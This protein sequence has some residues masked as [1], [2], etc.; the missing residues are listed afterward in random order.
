M[1]STNSKIRQTLALPKNISKAINRDEIKGCVK[2]AVL[3]AYL[4]PFMV[5]L[6]RQGSQE[7]CRQ[8]TLEIVFSN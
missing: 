2:G 1:D 4:T 6:S 3:D 8:K 7:S 5:M